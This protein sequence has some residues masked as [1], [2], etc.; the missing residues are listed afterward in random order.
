MKSVKRTNR[1]EEYAQNPFN[2]ILLSIQSEILL[3]KKQKELNKFKQMNRESHPKSF[4]QQ[5]NHY[6][7][8]INN[9][10]NSP[11]LFNNNNPFFFETP[12]NFPLIRFD[13]F[14]NGVSLINFQ[15][16]YFA[17]F[18]PVSNQFAPQ[19]QFF[20]P[21][22]F[23]VPF[24]PQ[25][26]QYQTNQPQQHYGG[27]EDISSTK[28][29][30]S[31]NI[32]NQN[33]QDSKRVESK[34]ISLVKN[35]APYVPSSKTQE[36]LES[37]QE[38]EPFDHK[39]FHQ[40]LRKLEKDGFEKAL[41]FAEI[42]IENYKNKDNLSL[43]FSDTAEMCKRFNQ[44][45]KARFYFRSSLNFC[46]Q[47]VKVWIEYAKMELEIGNLAESQAIFHWALTYHPQNETILIKAIK[48][49]ERLGN[50]K[51]ARNLLSTLR[52][53]NS[54]NKHISLPSSQNCED[55]DED[56]KSGFC[57]NTRWYKILLEGCLLEY[58]AGNI[59]ISRKI[60]KYLIANAPNYG[61]LYHEAHKMELNSGYFEK[62]LSVAEN[63]MKNTP[64][65]KFN[66]FLF[67][68]PK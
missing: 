6:E 49:E 38:E 29:N 47:R 65:V 9:Q 4:T 56:E 37:I 17:P 30:Q 62:S 1:F 22:N 36:I 50:L 25:F 68:L 2:D 10:S 39:K 59:N 31:Q 44:I 35:A 7:N 57:G 15:N 16:Q 23:Q 52:Q 26:F 60:I 11:Q 14:P 54:F 27:E 20:H 12:M 5:P 67:I 42:E 40:N 24:P 63:G 45:E 64:K 32:F 13:S 55:L 61:P 48:H 66:S 28:E 3:E 33:P 41:K 21:S 34:K 58:R 18:F 46:S 51:T 8:Q 19:N 53:R 43:I